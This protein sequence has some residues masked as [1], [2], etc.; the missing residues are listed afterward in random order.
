MKVKVTVPPSLGAGGWDDEAFPYGEEGSAF[1]M[2]TKAGISVP[3]SWCVPVSG[4]G[5]EPHG[6]IHEAVVYAMNHV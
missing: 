6:D 1:I 3:S 2:L 5:T 4:G